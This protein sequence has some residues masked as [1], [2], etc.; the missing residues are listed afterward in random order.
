L[1]FLLGYSS[2][3]PHELRDSLNFTAVKERNG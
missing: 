2:Q 1:N 3:R